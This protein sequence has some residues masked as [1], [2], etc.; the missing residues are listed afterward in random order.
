MKFSLPNLP[1]TIYLEFREWLEW[2]EAITEMTDDT[3]TIV[4]HSTDNL[5][6]VLLHE[7]IHAVS[8][9]LRRIGIHHTEE[10]EEIYAYTIWYFYKT[11]LSGVKKNIAKKQE[12]TCKEKR[13]K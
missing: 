1:V 3:A 13:N 4:L 7:V 11:I 10:C 9:Q 6:D 12:K 5:E 2:D 8:H